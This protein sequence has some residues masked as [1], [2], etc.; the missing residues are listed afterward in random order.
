MSA[1]PWWSEA[2]AADYVELY[3]HRDLLSAR[4]EARFLVG[5]GLAGRVLD[6][7]CGWGRHLIALDELGVSVAG[8][9]WSADLLARLREL[10]EGRRV[11]T[12]TVRGDA[13][14]PPFRDAA[15][16]GVVSLFS[17]FGYFGD[18][19]DARLLLGIAR[20]LAPGGVA[21][22][23]VMNPDA[24]RAELVP[25]SRKETGGATLVERR[26]LPGRSVRKDVELWRGGARVRTWHEEVRLYEPDELDARVRAAG[27]VPEAV[28]GDF[29]GSAFDR[30]APRQL[31]RVRRAPDGRPG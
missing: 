24:V 23:D 6:L 22:L 9:D 15:F 21:F 20:V 29:D 11:A 7:C 26:S 4:A 14:N 31:L 28:W 2:F 19:G 30:A 18:E 16:D 5:A 13:R 12:R 25:E 8:V 3:A 1:S 17:S 10:P 27:L